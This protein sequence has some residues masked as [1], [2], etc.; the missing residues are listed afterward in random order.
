M[1]T[2][3]QKHYLSKILNILRTVSQ[4]L[5]ITVETSDNLKKNEIVV[6]KWQTFY[7]MSDESADC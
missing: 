5:G 1:C 6:A 3:K 2:W 4:N 7:K